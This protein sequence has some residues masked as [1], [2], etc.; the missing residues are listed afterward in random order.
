MVF[1]SC[2]QSRFGHVK[3]TVKI[4]LTGSKVVWQCRWREWDRWDTQ[5][6]HGRME[7]RRIWEVLVYA[8]SM[9]RFKTSVGKNQGLTGP[10]Y[11]LLKLTSLWKRSLK[12][13]KWINYGRF[14]C[15]YYLLVINKQHFLCCSK[16]I[17]PPPMSM[18]ILVLLVITQH[19]WPQQLQQLQLYN[20]FLS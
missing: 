8:K 16:T 4:I 17:Y 13:Q 11:R 2:R 1:R 14:N 19:L 5:G 10:E 7:L 9:N 15:M 6:E 12:R 3:R 20:R 18:V